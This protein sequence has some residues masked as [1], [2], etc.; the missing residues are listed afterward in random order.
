MDNK[1][2]NDGDGVGIDVILTEDVEKGPH[3]A[4]G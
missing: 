4:H 2:E 3:C 1:T